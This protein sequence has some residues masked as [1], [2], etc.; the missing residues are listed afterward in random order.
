[1]K[2]TYLQGWQGLGFLLA[3]LAGGCTQNKPNTDSQQ[4]E[5]AGGGYAEPSCLKRQGGGAGS[6]EP[7]VDC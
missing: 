5:F 7:A 2:R 3:V 1:M 6:N 4:N